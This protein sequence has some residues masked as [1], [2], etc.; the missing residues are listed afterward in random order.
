MLLKLFFLVLSLN[1][2]S[3]SS[4]V[5]GC[6]PKKNSTRR[7]PR[8]HHSC[9]TL[10]LNPKFQPGIHRI[11]PSNSSSAFSTYCLADGWTLIMKVNSNSIKFTYNSTLWENSEVYNPEKVNL[12]NT[13]AKLESYY[14]VPF[15]EV[16]LLL[17]TGETLNELVLD[18]PAAS[19][20]DLMGTGEH[21]PTDLGRSAW[22]TLVPYSS[23]QYNCNREGFNCRSD[24]TGAYSRVRIGIIGNQENNCN[25]CDSWIGI[26]GFG[27]LCSP[28]AA[29]NTVGNFASCSA[30]NGD[31]NTFS[32]GYVFVR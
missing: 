5:E 31:R 20:K 2:V 29:N 25:S 21:H 15:D 16:L 30:D 22:K 26:G 28:H 12:D 18:Q 11:K 14:T 19:M 13:E 1:S 6:S 17:K 32:I 9:L 24:W 8:I 10:A 7:A 3:A 23:L 27:H 4:D